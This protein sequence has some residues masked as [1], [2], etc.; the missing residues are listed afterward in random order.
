LG[1]DATAKGV[2]NRDHLCVSLNNISAITA[3][4]CSARTGRA[5]M[6]MTGA[7]D[8]ET[9]TTFG[10]LGVVENVSV[11]HQTICSMKTLSMRRLHQAISNCDVADP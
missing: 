1:N 8:N 10:A 2:H 11:T 5:W 7:G 9:D 3:R 4:Q 6:N